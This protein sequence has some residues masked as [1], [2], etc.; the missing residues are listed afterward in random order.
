MIGRAPDRRRNG[1]RRYV[2][3]RNRKVAWCV[4]EYFDLSYGR[5]FPIGELPYG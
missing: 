1:R 4:H 5:N 3:P 2:I